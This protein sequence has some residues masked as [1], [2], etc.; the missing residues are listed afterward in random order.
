[1]SLLKAVLHFFPHLTELTDNKV[2]DF[3][4]I[5]VGDY[6]E[7]MAYQKSSTSTAC[8]SGLETAAGDT[9]K[10][11]ASGNDE[12]DNDLDTTADSREASGLYCTWNLRTYLL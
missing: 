12:I 11:A 5:P 8:A 2:E 9:R 10:D 1:M 7:E 6:P 4:D 3:Y